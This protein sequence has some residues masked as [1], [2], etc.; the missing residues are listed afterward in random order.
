[1]AT[2]FSRDSRVILLPDDDS[3]AIVVSLNVI[4]V[5]RSQESVVPVKVLLYLT[6]L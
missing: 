5:L 2:L 1:M 6:S 4:T 3:V